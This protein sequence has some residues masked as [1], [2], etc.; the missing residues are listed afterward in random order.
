MAIATDALGRR[1]R[2]EDLNKKDKN[3]RLRKYIEAGLLTLA[4]LAY[5]FAPTVESHQMW[6]WGCV[7]VR[8]PFALAIPSGKYETRSV[9]IDVGKTIGGTETPNL[10][11]DPDFDGGDGA[12]SKITIIRIKNTPIRLGFGTSAPKSAEKIAGGPWAISSFC[13]DDAPSTP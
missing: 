6:K 3:Q 12:L 11:A 7:G 10:L 13:R 2:I 8:T 1:P 9:R 5:F 4:T